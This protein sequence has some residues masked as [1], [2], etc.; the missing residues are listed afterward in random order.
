MHSQFLQTTILDYFKNHDS[1]PPDV[2]LLN[3][4][5]W[6]ISRFGESSVQE[7]YTS[8]GLFFEKCL[9]VGL[10]EEKYSDKNKSK[11]GHKTNNPLI[12]TSTNSH[13]SEKIIP[14]TPLILWRNALPIGDNA[15]GGFLIPSQATNDQQTGFRLDIPGAN[16][17]CLEKIASLKKDT[18]VE[19][20]DVHNFATCYSAFK[21][22]CPASKFGHF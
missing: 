3:S 5:V 7:Y 2:W 18:P 22:F 4:T 1:S 10:K 15:R 6:D 13:L 16:K 14:K 9:E 21:K 12:S 8:L 20:L 19:V 17:I 11:E